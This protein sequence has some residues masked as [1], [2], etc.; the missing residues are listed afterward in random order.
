MLRIII[1]DERFVV[2]LRLEGVLD[3]ASVPEYQ[4]AMTRASWER[5]DRKLLADVGDL[6]LGDTEAAAAI[7][8]G[9]PQGIGFVAA[10]GPIAELLRGQEEGNCKRECGLIR[11]LMFVLTNT[12]ASSP[13]PV[14]VRIYR[15][16]HSQL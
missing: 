8:E 9:R 15:L 3:A 4:D 14:C 16:L 2:K 13:R 6:R 5:R 1:F 10:Q 7:L 11:R 12:C